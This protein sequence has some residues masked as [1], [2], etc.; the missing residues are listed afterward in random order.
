MEK[1]DEIFLL[2][3]REKEPNSSQKNHKDLQAKFKE[4]YKK[5][6]SK[7]DPKSIKYL[8]FRTLHRQSSKDGTYFIRPHK[9]KDDLIGY[10]Q[11]NH[12]TSRDGLQIVDLPKSPWGSHNSYNEK[13]KFS[14]NHIYSPQ[15]IPSKKVQNFD[16]KLRLFRKTI[17]KIHSKS[18]RKE[19][20]YNEKNMIFKT[21]SG[22]M[23]C[24]KNFDTE[25]MYEKA[26]EKF[27]KIRE[28]NFENSEV[29]NGI[30]EKLHMKYE[31]KADANEVIKRLY[32][33]NPPIKK[34]NH[35]IKKYKMLWT[36]QY[37]D[38]TF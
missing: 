16:R 37:G 36:S 12:I 26:N 35:F 31:K 1:I 24:P 9:P 28:F 11:R 29:V 8:E 32:T 6:L 14:N 3:R 30:I 34:D 13:N 21:K 38:N 27:R 18:S 25:K 33:P 4:L 15:E 19:L 5:K 2:T 7:I 20:S 17:K 23:Y 10:L 22:N